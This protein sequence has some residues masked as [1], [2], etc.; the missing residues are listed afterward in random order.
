[1]AAEELKNSLIVLADRMTPEVSKYE[2][3]RVTV[4]SGAISQNEALRQL[5]VSS[6]DISSLIHGSHNIFRT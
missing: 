5:T 4:V 1:M 3:F 2:V 6:I